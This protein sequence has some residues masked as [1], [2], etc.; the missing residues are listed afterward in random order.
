MKNFKKLNSAKECS[1]V[2]R[3]VTSISYLIM[4]KQ[5]LIPQEYTTGCL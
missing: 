2:L 1:A 5:V 4:Q 3:L